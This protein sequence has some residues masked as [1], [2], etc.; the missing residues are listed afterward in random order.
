MQQCE[1]IL[2]DESQEFFI[3]N[4]CD[5]QGFVNFGSFCQDLVIE[6]CL[7]FKDFIVVKWHLKQ[8]I[9]DRKKR[10]IVLL[11]T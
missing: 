8:T 11:D 2:E 3:S 4:L 1:I 9:G 6:L 7:D 5:E 10:F